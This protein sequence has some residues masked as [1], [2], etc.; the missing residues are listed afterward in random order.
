M[1]DNDRYPGGWHW[2]WV[3]SLDELKSIADENGVGLDEV[4]HNEWEDFMCQSHPVKGI[5]LLHTFEA[6]G[7]LSVSYSLKT[8]GT[9]AM[10]AEPSEPDFQIQGNDVTKE[11]SIREVFESP[12][13]NSIREYMNNNRAHSHVFRHHFGATN[14]KYTCSIVLLGCTEASTPLNNQY[15]QTVSVK[16]AIE[17]S[18]TMHYEIVFTIVEGNT[19]AVLNALESKDSAK[20][21]NGCQMVM[22]WFEDDMSDRLS[23]YVSQNFAS[24]NFEDIWENFIIEYGRRTFKLIVEEQVFDSL[25]H[26]LPKD[27]PLLLKNLIE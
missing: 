9:V 16:T 12:T 20:M 5:A 11:M 21:W 19:S 7:G 4:K 2:F 10:D 1:E 8:D 14:I 26:G 23:E 27:H 24:T 3:P 6:L 15:D 22:E 25:L 13:M 18:M 17:N